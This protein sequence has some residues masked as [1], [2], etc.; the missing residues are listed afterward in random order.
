MY[1]PARFPHERGEMFG[2]KKPTSLF[3]L[4]LLICPLA[5]VE[6]MAP[7]SYQELLLS[8]NTGCFKSIKGMNGAQIFL[9]RHL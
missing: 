2:Q 1:G 8:R 9:L 7:G 6:D 5:K 4:P 3:C